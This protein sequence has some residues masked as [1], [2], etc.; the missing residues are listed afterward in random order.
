MYLSGLRAAFGRAAE[1][2]QDELEGLYEMLTAM[3]QQVV[4][5]SS[6]EVLEHGDWGQQGEPPFPEADYEVFMAKIE[7]FTEM[8]YQARLQAHV[9]AQGQAAVGG[10]SQ[11]T[12]RSSR[13]QSR[14][15]PAGPAPAPGADGISSTRTRSAPSCTI[16]PRS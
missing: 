10:L 9:H 12:H 13:T 6:S 8:L 7:N 3:F 2:K 16:S 15:D 11:H 5:M 4:D 14:Q 1:E